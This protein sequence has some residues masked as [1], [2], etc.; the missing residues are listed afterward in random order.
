MPRV[1]AIVL[2]AGRSTRMGPEN[3]LLADLGGK[4]MVRHVVEAALASTARPVLVVTGHQAA[5]VADALAGLDVTLVANPAYATGLASSLKAGIRAVPAA[6][7]GALILLGDMPRVAPGHIERL[8]AALA[9]EPESIIVPVHDG[10]R[11]N[12]V[13]WPR[14]YFSELLQLEGDA[15]ARRLFAAHPGAVREVAA[16]DDAILSD[17]DTPE[18]LLRI[19]GSVEAPAHPL[20]PL[21][22]RGSG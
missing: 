12:P 17:I 3:K 7:D 14:R 4:P 20:S 15:G 18:A 5:Q 6:C 13:L 21:A 1:A 16:A 10:Q 9:A 8:I 11:G 19:R 2:A 22:G